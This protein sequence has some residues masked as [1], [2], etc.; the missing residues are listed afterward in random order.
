MNRKAA[1]MLCSALL[2][3]ATAASGYEVDKKTSEIEIKSVEDFELCIKELSSAIEC[4][5]GLVRYA[6]RRPREALRAG[7]RARLEYRS[8]A[9][10]PLFEIALRK[11]ADPEVCKDEDL[12]ISLVSALGLPPTTYD[13][14][15]KQAK[16]I[17]GK[18][19]DAVKDAVVKEAQDRN[20]YYLGNACPVMVTKGLLIE[21]CQPKKE[22]PAAAVETGPSAEVARLQGMQW[23]TLKLDQQSALVMRGAEDEQVLLV[24]AKGQESLYVVKFKN[25]RGPWNNQV[26]VAHERTVDRGEREFVTLVDGAE[27]ILV[28]RRSRWAAGMY[29]AYPKGYVDGLKVYRGAL[30]EQAGPGSAAEVVGEFK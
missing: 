5:D 8:W 20:S 27:W 24:R 4:L 12:S 1:L 15:V 3:T 9:A 13:K 2:L 25:V 7:K 10:L 17:A 30:V 28:T 22:E 19:W 16:D 6:E 23:R 14:Q 26:F 21:P 11:K 18:C 29:E